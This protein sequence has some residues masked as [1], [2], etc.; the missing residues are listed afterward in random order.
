MTLNKDTLR[1]LGLA[2]RAG[3]VRSGNFQTEESVKQKKAKL[4][5]IASDAA[6]ASKKHISDMCRFNGVPTVEAELTRSEL[7]HSIGKDDRSSVTIEDRG[8][9][10][11][12]LEKSEGGNACGK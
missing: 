8:F 11:R 6:D 3:F 7:G 12:I 5:I 9:A 4:C 2:Q 10:E 1:L